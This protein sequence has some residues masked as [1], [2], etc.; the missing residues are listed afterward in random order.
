MS[1][2]AMSM[3][4]KNSRKSGKGHRSFFNHTKN[5]DRKLLELARQKKILQ[6]VSSNTT[7]QDLTVTFASLREDV[8]ENWIT[9]ETDGVLQFCL[10]IS[11]PP[12]LV[13]SRS[14][15]VQPDL[16]W[17]VYVTGN[18]VPRSNELIQQLAQRVSSVTCL[19]AILSA[20]ESIQSDVSRES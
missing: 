4:T 5:G 16:T 18:V 1:L 15:S 8:P 11:N 2:A 6:S 20:V 12:S 9:K 10:V 14:V 3:P 7:R 13:I 17:Y 19:K